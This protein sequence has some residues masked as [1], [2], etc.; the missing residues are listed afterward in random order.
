MHIG[1]SIEAGAVRFPHLRRTAVFAQPYRN[2]IAT[3]FTLTLF[4]AGIGAIE[5]LV[6]KQIFDALSG[7]SAFA[8]I[9][10]GAGVLFLLVLV[11]E[12]ASARSHWLSWRTRLD[13]YEWLLGLAIGK[14]QSMPLRE[15]RSE[16]VGGLV[17]RLDRAL[18]GVLGAMSQTLFQAVPTVLFL[19]IAAA[20]MI[21]LD[22]RLALVALAF[23]PLPAA[24]AVAAAPE[25]IQRERSL[26]DGWSRIFSRFTD[27][28]GARLPAWRRTSATASFGI[29]P[30]PTRS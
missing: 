24:F 26:F 11:R 18:Q 6:L 15:Q 20:V 1:L 27:R 25:Q 30:K 5:P 21:S 17:S 23:A 10:V 19:I 7:A 9:A 28:D 13:I 12:I 2:A 22:W 8:D 16:G 4:T 29:S 14:L 3:I